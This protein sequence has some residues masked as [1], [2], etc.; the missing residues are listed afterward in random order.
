MS[1]TISLQPHHFEQLDLA[2]VTAQL[3]T[4]NHPESQI[5]FDIEYPQE[6]EDP[7]ELPEISEVRLWFI[8]LD[9]VYPWLPYVLD[10]RSGELARYAAMLV[11]HQF[12]EGEGIQYNPQALDIFVMSKLFVIHRWLRDHGVHSPQKLKQ[13]AEMFGYE[14]APDLFQLLDSQPH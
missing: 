7:R 11:P 14:I 9:A 5:R 2:P 3:T 4:L 10:W 6:E 13:M 12:S 8:R 1:L